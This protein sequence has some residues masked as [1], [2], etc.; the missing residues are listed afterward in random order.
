MTQ[1][2]LSVF[3]ALGLDPDEL[4][5]QDFAICTGQDIRRFH[6]WYENSTRTAQLTDAMCMSCPVRKIC[7][8]SGMENNEW[9]VWGGV[10][11]TNGKLD[12]N[13]NAHKT[14]EDWDNIKNS[15]MQS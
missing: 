2:I 7:L 9:G 3:D 4:R 1:E 5:W 14:Q 8:Q 6:E 13:K 11:L 15:I 12:E 10:F